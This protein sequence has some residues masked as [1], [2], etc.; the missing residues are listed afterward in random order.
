MFL[1]II[2]NAINTNAQNF[3][4]NITNNDQENYCDGLREGI[5]NH[6]YLTLTSANTQTNTVNYM[7]IIELDEQ[8]NKVDS[9]IIDS[10]YGKVNTSQS[11]IEKDK[12]NL[13]YYTLLHDSNNNYLYTRVFDTS[14]QTIKESIIDTLLP[15]EYLIWHITNKKGQHIFLTGVYTSEWYDFKIYETDSNYNLIKKVNTGF[16][17]GGAESEVLK[18]SMVEMPIDSGYIIESFNWNIK[19]DYSFN[20]FD[21]IS[22]RV[23]PINIT[24]NNTLKYND[25][26][27][28]ENVFSIS[29]GGM[30]WQETYSG[31]YKRT[32]NA[33][34][35]DSIVI[36]THVFDNFVTQF[37][38]FMSFINPDTLYYCAPAI[39]YDSTNR[40]ILFV[41]MDKNGNVFWQKY[42]HIAYYINDEAISATY[43]G[44]CV[45]YAYYF[46]GSNF[47][48]NV[49]VVKSDKNGNIATG[50]NE[51]INVSDKQILVYPNP[52]NNYINFGTGLYKNPDIKIYNINGQL[53]TETVLKQGLNT[54]DISKFANGMY[55]YKIWDKGRFIE[56]GKF[57]KE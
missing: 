50:I 44:G 5:N 45:I 54:I 11:G 1:L 10:I 26:I 39:H 30:P 21:T 18:V 8:G 28:F 9:V 41:K 24:F 53:Q 29:D 4:K 19:T 34:I 42:F 36:V 40:C 17:D 27:Y 20:S 48:S 22:S 46:D 3:V 15:N 2:G 43:D 14:I 7:A 55:F 51:N 32:R 16:G 56:D 33:V 23:N 13:L 57:V 49:I 6:Y 35:V 12:N 52:A 37:R 31:I 38:D 25:S 47:Q